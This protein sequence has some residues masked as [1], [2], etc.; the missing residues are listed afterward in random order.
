M[1]PRVTNGAAKQHSHI[2]MLHLRA[3]TRQQSQFPASRRGKLI[4]II[5]LP[6]FFLFFYGRFGRIGQSRTQ[7]EQRTVKRG[8]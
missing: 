8:V 1:G 7:P 6:L 5:I 4:I 2:E 3:L